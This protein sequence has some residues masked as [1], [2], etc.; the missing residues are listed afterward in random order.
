MQYLF[1]F[2]NKIFQKRLQ[3]VQKDY[4]EFYKFLKVYLTCFGALNQKL[5]KKTE[6]R[7]RKRKYDI[8]DDVIVFKVGT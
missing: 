7:N 3:C 1:L 8:I 2:Q 6:N 5:E 4:F